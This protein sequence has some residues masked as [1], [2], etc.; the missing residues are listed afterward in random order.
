MSASKLCKN[1][2][3]GQVIQL[4]RNNYEKEDVRR[5]QLGWAAFGKLSQVFYSPIPQ[6]EK[7][8]TCSGVENRERET[9]RRTVGRPPARWTHDLKKVAGSGWMRNAESR[10]WWRALGKTCVQQW[11]LAG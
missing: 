3:Q 8:K 11:M 7:T 9:G 5:I 2:Y 4:G 6:S 10:V 1:N